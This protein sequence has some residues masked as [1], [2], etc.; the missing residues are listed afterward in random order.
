MKTLK[1][2]IVVI[3]MI[4]LLSSCKSTYHTCPTYSKYPTKIK[5]VKYNDSVRNPDIDRIFY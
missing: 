5:E 1:L 4:L 2:A 3:I